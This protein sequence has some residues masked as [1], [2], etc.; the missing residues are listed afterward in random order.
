MDIPSVKMWKV[1]SRRDFH[2]GYQESNFGHI[3]NVPETLSGHV[4]SAGWI[5]GSGVK[6]RHSSWRQPQYGGWC[7]DPNKAVGQTSDGPLY[8]T[9]VVPFG[10]G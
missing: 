6:W 3:T 9:I 2:R 7:V 8:D 5:H 10:A 1:S 4:Q